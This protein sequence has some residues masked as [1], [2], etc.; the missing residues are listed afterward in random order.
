MQS[1]ELIA[2]HFSS[3]SQEFL[4]LKVTNLPPNVQ[5]LLDDQNKDCVPLLSTYDVYKRMVKA[6]KPN[7]LVPGDLHPKLVKGFADI[8]PR[9]T[10]TLV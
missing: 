9:F 3:I 2:S 7:S 5:E 4:P 1:A 8:L 6:K 10:T